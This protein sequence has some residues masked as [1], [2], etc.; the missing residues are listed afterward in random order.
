MKKPSNIKEFTLTTLGCKVNQYESEQIAKGLVDAGFIYL[1]AT[2]ELERDRA[3]LC[4]INTCTVT[5]KASMQSRQAA[6]QAIRKHPDAVVIVTGC[7]AQTDPDAIRKI[8]GVHHI[9][10]LR[11]N[12]RIPALAASL[13]NTTTAAKRDCTAHACEITAVA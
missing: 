6:R 12:D 11:D 8:K 7:Y 9:L 4:I 2:L 1:D 3:D 13:V 5:H 10:P